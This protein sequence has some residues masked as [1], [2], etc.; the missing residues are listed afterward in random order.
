MIRLRTIGLAATALTGLWLAGRSEAGGGVRW[1][2]G[3]GFGTPV[4][5]R[6]Y[7]PYYYYPYYPYR[8]V[9]VEPAP[10][11]VP[12]PVVVQSAPVMQSPSP[13]LQPVQQTPTLAPVTANSSILEAS[14]ADVEFHL[15]QLADA[16]ENTRADSVLQLGRLKAARAIDPL[17][18]TLAGDRSSKVREAAARALALIGSPKALPALQQAALADSDR[19]V[20]R[21]AQFAVDVVQNAR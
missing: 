10:V 3:V 11:Y 13:G 4:Y 20:R 6:P 21:S 14:P 15:R 18:A 9:Y 19:D 12:P 8:A 5:Y 16:N 7:G 2:V 17:A 1:S